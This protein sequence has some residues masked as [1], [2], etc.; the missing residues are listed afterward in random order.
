MYQYL[1]HVEF[2]AEEPFSWQQQQ[3]HSF[4]VMF[5]KQANHLWLLLLGFGE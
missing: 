4:Q 1:L 3:N 5:P 2:V